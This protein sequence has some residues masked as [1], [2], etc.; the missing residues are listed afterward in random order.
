MHSGTF[1]R[2]SIFQLYSNHSIAILANSPLN[3]THK[4]VKPIPSMC[5]RLLFQQVVED[6]MG[7]PA[8]FSNTDTESHTVTT[9]TT[10]EYE[11][12]K[13]TIWQNPVASFTPQVCALAPPTQQRLS[14]KIEDVLF[15][16]KK[17]HLILLNWFNKLYKHHEINRTLKSMFM[18]FSIKE[19]PKNEVRVR[20]KWLLLHCF[21]FPV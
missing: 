6:Y 9:S 18:S 2:I 3:R 11:S 5:I 15:R 16:N 8:F 17:R 20:S 10:H 1:S 12:K 4:T 14:S 19:I 7:H 13:P 21:S